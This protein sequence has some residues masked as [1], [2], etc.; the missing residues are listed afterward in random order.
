[1]AAGAAA[2]PSWASA[3]P[4]AAAAAGGLKLGLASYSMRKFTLDQTLDLCKELGLAYINLKDVHL[5]MTD[6]PEALAAAHKKVEAAGL[7]LMGG[8]TITLKNEEAQ[9]RKAFDYARA[10]GFPLMVTA[11]DPAAFDI[12]E[13]LIVETGIKVAVHN[14]GPEDKNFPA[15]QDAYKL[16]KGRDKRFGLCMD[17]GHATRAKVDIVK[18]VDEVKDRLLDVHVKDLKDKNDKESQTE[19]GKGAL[20]IA[21]FFRALKRVGFAG[22]VGLEYEI[23]AESP[24]VGIKESFAFM[25]G[26]VA[27]L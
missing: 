13:K 19:V 20:D 5:P 7:T 2:A 1:V 16:L 25:R 9:V 14:H 27:A 24:Q 23:N 6:S 17:I 22:H 26:V 11:P 10:A 15:P 3:S 8:G 18:T 4:A 12:I 21:G